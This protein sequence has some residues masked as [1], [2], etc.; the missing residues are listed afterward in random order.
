MKVLEAIKNKSHFVI[1]ND[2]SI[3]AIRNGNTTC[4]GKNSSLSKNDILNMEV[5]KVDNIKGHTE[6]LGIRI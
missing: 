5:L 4:Y 3:L 1:T 2:G 6:Y